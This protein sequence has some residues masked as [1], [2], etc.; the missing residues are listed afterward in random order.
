MQKYCV[1]LPRLLPGYIVL[2]TRIQENIGGNMLSLLSRGRLTPGR[3]CVPYGR[4]WLCLAANGTN[5]LS[6]SHARNLDD[7]VSRHAIA[8]EKDIESFWFNFRKHFRRL[9]EDHRRFIR[10]HRERADAFRPACEDTVATLP[11]L[12]SRCIATLVYVFAESALHS[13]PWDS[14]WDELPAAIKGRLDEFNHLELAN[15]AWAFAAIDRYDPD[16]FDAFALDAIRRFESRDELFKPSHLMQL[17]MGFAV[18]GH[19]SAEMFA[20]IA[21]AVVDQSADF[22]AKQLANVAWAFAAAG[23]EAPELFDVV[24]AEMSTETRLKYLKPHH[25][26]N[27]AWALVKSRTPSPELLDALSK[28]ISPL[29]ISDFDDEGIVK[30]SWAFGSAGHPVPGQLGSLDASRIEDTL[31][32]SDS[33]N[34]RRDTAIRLKYTF[35][36]NRN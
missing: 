9:P 4:R 22:K 29:E 25:V 21:R 36:G 3:P 18:A 11:H 17:A 6:L 16:L 35:I 5:T 30:L 24:E 12:S 2:C 15:S 20:S 26:A 14:A 34:G 23:H 8:P 28:C 10:E 31:R 32:D 7:L 27:L 33:A 19:S 1:C 13:P